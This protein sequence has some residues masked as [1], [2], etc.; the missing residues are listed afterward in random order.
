MGDQVG[1]ATGDPV[2]SWLEDLYRQCRTNRSALTLYGRCSLFQIISS[3]VS[4]KRLPPMRKV[5]VLAPGTR[6]SSS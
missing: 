3:K 5:I 6:P 2:H 1:V 4:S